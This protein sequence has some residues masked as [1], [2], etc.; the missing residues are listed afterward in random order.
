MCQK[1]GFTLTETILVVALIIILSSFTLAS[2][3]QGERLFSLQ[4]AAHKLAQDLSYTRDMAM[5]GQKTSASCG[6]I[7]PSGGYG[8]YFSVG[9][10]SYILFADCNNNGQYDFVPEKIEEIFLESRI[11]IKTLLPSSPISITF[12][13][14]DPVITITPDSGSGSATVTL[15]LGEYTKDIFFTTAGLIDIN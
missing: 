2:H 9:S 10:N 13:P 8:L 7:F 14:P 15:F 4:R 3:R 12:F 1:K 11:T 6:G 5:R